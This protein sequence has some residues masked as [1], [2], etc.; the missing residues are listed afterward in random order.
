MI[1]SDS[2]QAGSIKESIARLLSSERWWEPEEF[3]RPSHQDV[4][5]AE[6]IF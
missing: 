5:L 1:V 4:D 2:R 6:L 3:T